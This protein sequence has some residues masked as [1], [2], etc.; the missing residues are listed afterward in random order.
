MFDWLKNMF[1]DSSESFDSNLH[2]TLQKVEQ[3]AQQLFER[4]FEFEKKDISEPVI[5]MI[6]RINEDDRVTIRTPEGMGFMGFY[7]LEFIGVGDYDLK[8]FSFLIDSTH[9]GVDYIE[10]PWMKDDEKIQLFVAIKAKLSR[11]IHVRQQ[12]DREEF[13]SWLGVK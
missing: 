1:G 4:E 7:Y 13:S 11:D 8:K 9:T 10:C 12:A 3:E 2:T 6:K 5:E